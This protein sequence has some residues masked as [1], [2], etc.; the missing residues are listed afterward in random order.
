MKVSRTYEVWVGGD[1][2]EDQLTL[3]EAREL[4]TKEFEREQKEHPDD[5][6][7]VVVDEHTYVEIEHVDD[8]DT[9]DFLPKWRDID[10]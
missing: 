3:D 2:I 10:V 8:L 9:V 7:D 5:P 1:M 4:A 6:V